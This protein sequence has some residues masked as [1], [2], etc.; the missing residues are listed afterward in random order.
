MKSTT[1][2]KLS[3]NSLAFS[4][5]AFRLFLL[6]VLVMGWYACSKNESPTPTN[7]NTT[8]EKPAVDS[9]RRSFTFSTETANLA[10]SGTR[11]ARMLGPVKTSSQRSRYGG[12]INQK[13][14]A[15]GYFY[16]LQT[17]NKG[18]IL[19]DP[20]GYYFL[21]VGVNTVTKTSN[22]SVTDS[23]W[24]IGANTLG[25]WS[26]ETLNTSGGQKMAYTPRWN[27]MLQFKN[28]NARR[29]SLYEAGIIPVF[30]PEFPAFADVT[31]KQAAL[32]KNDPYVL[33][34]F[35]DNELP[36]YDNTLYG[37][38]LDRFL[39]IADKNDPNYLAAH[40]W[41][42]ARKGANYAI[43]AA[44]REEFH[45]YVAG[46][47]YR[48]GNEA[49][50]KYDPNHLNL[51]SRLHGGARSNRFIFRE[52]GKYVDVVS[53]NVYS[54]WTLTTA[55]MDMW[56]NESGKPFFITEFY[57]KATDAGLTNATGAGWLVKTQTDRARFFENFTLALLEHRG[58]VGFH[59]FRYQD[60]EDTNNGLLGASN[61]WWAPLRASYYKVARDVYFLRDALVR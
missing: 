50:R 6:S 37:L 58:C 34:Y 56:H 27:L 31:L 7:P 43:S 44:D 52:A 51:G 33:G 40:T 41:M 9:T 45:G 32:Y 20:E 15:K 53:V 49:L 2:A 11:S 1:L 21:T 59:H 23:L 35:M 47:Y 22:W 16:T 5:A 57:A 4:M 12:W 38:L 46:T 24:A 13:T 48:I 17:P 60:D 3:L 54:T 61:R 14:T 25:S 39:A 8:G 10:P 26:D 29:K 42:V 18:W 28:T 36:L 30:D 19:V 55:E